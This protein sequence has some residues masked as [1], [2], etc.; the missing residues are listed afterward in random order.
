MSKR[1]L[2]VVGLDCLEPTLAFE[3]WAD[4]MPNLTRLR[5]QGAWSRLRSTVP[6][7]T[8]PAWQAMC[9]S[10]DPGTLGMYGFR[11][12][13]D[14]SYSGMRFADGESIKE[15]RVWDHLSRAGL[16]N[17]ILGVPQ[18]YP[19]R[20]L[21]GCQISGFPMPGLEGRWA[22]PAALK[23]EV[24]G[25][26]DYIYDVGEFRTEHKQEILDQLITM[27]ERRFKLAK[28]LLET[29]P[30][31]FFM[32]VEMGTDR[33]VH[34][35]WR[36]TDETH[37]H[38][39]PNHPLNDCMKDY[40]ALCDKLLGEMTEKY[41]NDPDVA[42]AVVSD[43]GAQGMA[44]GFHINEWLIR[45]G[46]LKLKTAPTEPVGMGKMIKA[47]NVDWNH[48]KVWA[49]GGYY[50]RVMLNVFGREPNGCVRPEE[51][52]GL[53]AELEAKFKAIPD[54]DGNPMQT[55]VF[56]PQQTYKQVNNVAP[57]MILIF[58]DL[59]WRAIGSIRPEAFGENP[60]EYYVYENDTGPDDANHAW[61]GSW[62]IAGGG[63]PQI[64]ETDAFSLLDIAPSI[65]RYFGLPVPEDFQGEPREYMDVAQTCPVGA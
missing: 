55:R 46:Y 12:R 41:R 54:G 49:E 23:D 29:K 42:I 51:V 43:H 35:L 11:N 17:I 18:T 28:H 21:L 59:N 64:G 61:H 36:F 25:V 52:E 5:E 62:A 22:Y 15:M 53:K 31:D 38:Y 63:I 16:R 34:L 50:S 60:P 33:I 40:Y 56:D 48:T 20:P 3:K 44:G 4:V 24:L 2:I 45:N 19:A 39:V 26:C 37:R 1:K 14:H 10:K 32:M 9:T 13:L 30:W 7:I 47:D 65:M 58:D 8:I 6:P 27:A 57:D